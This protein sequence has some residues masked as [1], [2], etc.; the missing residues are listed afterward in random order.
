MTESAPSRQQAQKISAV[1]RKGDDPNFEEQQAPKGNG[2]KKKWKRGK[3]A[4]R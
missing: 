3:R 2:S 1:K 4:G